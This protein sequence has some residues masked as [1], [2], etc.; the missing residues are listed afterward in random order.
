MAQIKIENLVIALE[1]MQ[2]WCRVM[3]EALKPIKGQ[4]LEITE[5]AEKELVGKARENV[6][7]CRPD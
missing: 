6:G 4:T 7:S 1:N 2:E 5:T 3:A